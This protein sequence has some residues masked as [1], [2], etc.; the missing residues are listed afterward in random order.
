MAYKITE[1]CIRCGVCEIE[2]PDGAIFRGEKRFVID[3]ARCTEC[4]GN[5]AI[6]KCVAICP[7]EACVPA[8][9]D[10]RKKEK[11]PKNQRN[12]YSG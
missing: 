2:C 6:P 10:I 11:P 5:G 9:T 7:V 8:L 1:Y 3:A 4:A 12:P